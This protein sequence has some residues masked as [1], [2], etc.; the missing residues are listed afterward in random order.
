MKCKHI[1]MY[2]LG[3]LIFTSALQGCRQ[4]K[5]APVNN[6]QSE[7]TTSINNASIR[8]DAFPVI[9]LRSEWLEHTYDQYEKGHPVYVYA[10]ESV[11]KRAEIALK[12]RPPSVLDKNIIAASGDKKDYFSVGPYWWPNPAKADGMPW[13]QKDGQVNP[14]SKGKG[15]DKP[16]MNTMLFNISHLAAA[17]YFTKDEKFAAHVM[18]NVDSWF[19][20]PQTGMNPNLN[21]G[22]AIPGTADGR[23][24]GIIESRWWIRMLDDIALLKGSASFTAEHDEALKKWMA[25]YLDWLVTSPLGIGECNEFNNHGTY[26]KAQV[27]FFAYYIGRDDLARK[28]IREAMESLLPSQVEANGAQPHELE[29]TR[30][31]HYSLFNLEAFVYMAR[32]GDHLGLDFWNY[33][34]S[35]GASIKAMIDYLLPAIKNSGNWKSHPPKKKT[36]VGRLY[37]FVYLAYRQYGDEKYAQALTDLVDVIEKEDRSEMTQCFLFMPTPPN[38]TISDMQRID[39]QGKKSRSRCYF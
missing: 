24:F 31:L 4:I 36:R 15:S 18:R 12:K 16:A 20:S 27:A 22:Q 17:Y 28:N 10:V 13:L 23:I 9:N 26:C 11:I 6:S 38:F 2:L 30:P 7:H 21:H 19:L 34:A 29:R 25:S 3:L 39:P 1:C 33:T 35:N 5:E 37:Y 8:S 14:T 32:L